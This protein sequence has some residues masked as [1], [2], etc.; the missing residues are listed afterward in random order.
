MQGEFYNRYNTPLT[1]EE[2]KGLY[3]WLMELSMQEGR[4]AYSDLNDYDMAGAYKEGLTKRINADVGGI[5]G[6]G[7]FFYDYFK[8]PNHPV[9]S[10]DSKYHGV[11]GYYGGHWTEGT[12]QYPGGTFTPSEWNLQNMDKEDMKWYFAEREPDARLILPG[13]ENR[14]GGSDMAVIYANKGGGGLG[15]FLGPLSLVSAFVPGLQPVAAGL[16]AVNSA[17]QGDVAGT[18]MNG[19]KMIGGM[20][21][22]GAKTG[23]GTK[24]NLQ[25]QLNDPQYA[26]RNLSAMNQPNNT[27][28]ANPAMQYA[29]LSR[30]Y[31]NSMNTIGVNDALRAFMG[32]G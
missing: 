18:L 10:D 11:D 15:G 9:F 16:G 30:P 22:G 6:T 20:G 17:M 5:N 8:K 4:N 29:D 25:S 1:P 26:A 21:G 24:V 32:R 7:G 31:R 3:E 19:A 28:T 23:G 12:E 13:D 14:N 27:Q 2:R